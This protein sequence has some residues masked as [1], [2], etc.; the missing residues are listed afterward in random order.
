MA[1]CEPLHEVFQDATTEVLVGLTS[2]TS[3]LKHPALET[4]YFHEYI[5]LLN[6]DGVGVKHYQTEFGL[7]GYFDSSDLL[8]GRLAIYLHILLDHAIQNKRQPVLKFTR[9]LARAT[10]LRRR[11]PE[12]AQI[13]LVRDPLSQFQSSWELAA[14]QGNFSFLANPLLVL[15]RPRQGPVRR[16]SD[17]LGIPYVSL[18]K[19]WAAC[20][21]AYTDLARTLPARKLFTAFLGVYVAGR[22][23]SAPVADLV[24]DQR[25]LESSA[26]YRI[27]T[28]R[29]LHAIS[30][31]R[32]DLSD[33]R[34]TTRSRPSAVS[35]SGGALEDAAELVCAAFEGEYGLSSRAI[36]SLLSIDHCH[37]RLLA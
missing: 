16:L 22:A 17:K 28:E 21:T 19:G 18:D 32:V 11:F 3:H 25:A 29:Q 2:E 4:P 20:I 13:L 37:S 6:Q 8:Q 1:Y 36:L 34:V 33:C 27:D 26:R 7:P 5:D 35:V 30:G 24:I 9:A 10:W 31:L 14:N 12:A 23:M 15:S